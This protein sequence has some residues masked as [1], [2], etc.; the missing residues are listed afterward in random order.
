MRP[1]KVAVAQLDTVLGDCEQNLRKVSVVAEAQRDKDIVVFPEMM[2][3]GYDVGPSLATVCEQEQAWIKEL[4]RL[5]A[6]HQTT[7][8]VG[9]PRHDGE[10]FY[11]AVIAVGP[12]GSTL[13]VYD[14]THLYASESQFYKKGTE[15][16]TVDVPVADGAVRC[17]IEI[18]YDLEFPEVSRSLTK[19]GAQILCIASANMHPWAWHHHVYARSRAMENQVFALYSNRVGDEGSISFCGGSAIVGPQG[20][21]MDEGKDSSEAIL[22][23]ELDLGEIER[24]AESDIP[25]WRDRR[26]ELYRQ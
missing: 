18:C 7:L 25:Y 2:V 17:G 11:N 3:T 10:G 12:N 23:A 21:V 26:E 20:D 14:K 5:A 9:M 4:Q 13:G 24:M 8:I 19:S 16:L 6:Q 1:V 15:F 22:Q